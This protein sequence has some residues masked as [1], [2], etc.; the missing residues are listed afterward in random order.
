MIASKIGT[1]NLRVGRES[2]AFILLAQ[3][4]NV[5]AIISERQAQGVGP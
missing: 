4:A 2:F 5:T 3:C 1:V